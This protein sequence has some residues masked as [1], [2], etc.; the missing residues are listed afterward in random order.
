MVEAEEDDLV[1]DKSPLSPLFYEAQAVITQARRA[2]E[3]RR[4]EPGVPP[5]R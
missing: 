4:A 3:K 1:N 2:E 5:E